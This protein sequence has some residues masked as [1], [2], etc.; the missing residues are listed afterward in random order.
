MNDN[1]DVN[2]LEDD[3]RNTEMRLGEATKLRDEFIEKADVLCED[4]RE[5][6]KSE[7]SGNTLRAALFQIRND[8]MIAMDRLSNE[9]D[10][11]PF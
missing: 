1:R 11:I 8:L 7:I 2:Q 3:L 9:E 5:L 6:T 4:L 10:H